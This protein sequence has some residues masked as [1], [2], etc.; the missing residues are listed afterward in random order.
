VREVCRRDR[1]VAIAHGLEELCE[2]TVKPAKKKK[3]SKKE[4]TEE[5]VLGDLGSGQL[6]G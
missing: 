4:K 2:V 3:G 5:P 1:S 6:S